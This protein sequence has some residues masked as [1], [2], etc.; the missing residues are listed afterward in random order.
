MYSSNKLYQK[1][2]QFSHL[3]KTYK[4]SS[5]IEYNFSMHFCK[6]H[7]YMVN[8]SESDYFLSSSRKN[9]VLH[10]GEMKNRFVF[11]N[12]SWKQL[13]VF[14]SKQFDFT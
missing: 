6:S 2:N 12:L 3:Y 13:A 4:I 5:F 8:Q 1:V 9:I 14:I 11:K 7:F 10:Y